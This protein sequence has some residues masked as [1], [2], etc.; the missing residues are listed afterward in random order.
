MI[1]AISGNPAVFPV[2]CPFVEHVIHPRQ[3]GITRLNTLRR[4]D[5]E[6]RFPVLLA[7]VLRAASA[8]ADVAERAHH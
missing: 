7:T 8:D 3:I 4:E 5:L 2:R 6:A 1:D